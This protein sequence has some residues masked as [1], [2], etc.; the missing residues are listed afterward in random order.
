MATPVARIL[1]GLG[2]QPFPN[3]TDF[4]LSSSSIDS[5]CAKVEQIC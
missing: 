4:V 1:R 2:L 3:G 5:L